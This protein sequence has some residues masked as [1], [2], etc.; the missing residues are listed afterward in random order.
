M[1]AL[2]LGTSA[3][4]LSSSY[5]RGDVNNDGIVNG[6]DVNVLINILLGK[7]VE[8]T[9]QPV[10]I[11]T[12]NGVEFTM[13]LVEHGTFTMGAADDD[14][15]AGDREK[16]AHQVTLTQ[17]F[18]IG[19]TE[20]TQELWQAVMGN[21]PSYFNENG[22][23]SAGSAHTGY[24]F[25]TNLQRPVEYVSWS[26]CQEFIAK[27]NQIT[28]GLFRLP[29]E[30]EWEFAA[31]GGNLSQG[32][33]YAGS[34]D[35]AAVAWYYDNTYA[36]GI[37]NPDYGTHTVATL[38]PNELGLYDMSGNVWEW[39]QDW[40]NSNYYSVSP[41]NDPTGPMYGTDPVAR[42]GCWTLKASGS[43]LSYRVARGQTRRDRDLGFR[44]AL[45]LPR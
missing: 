44:L 45:S 18:Y 38:S 4:R 42:G 3:Q 13:V 41:E 32:F 1:M 5:L 2:S 10:E 6:S 33:K 26:D 14:S 7:Y 9:Y 34:D 19:Q 30:A 22:S 27:L 31:R 8:P 43:R 28:G 21:N 36:L 16:P 20:V 15:D 17:D 11:M 24:Y 37:S 23:S 39:C 35:I 12:I 40:Y 29:T 25:E